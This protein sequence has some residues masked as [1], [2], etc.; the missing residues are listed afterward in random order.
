MFTTVS[1]SNDEAAQE[2]KATEL[3]KTEFS[4]KPD[5]AHPNPQFVAEMD[6]LIEDLNQDPEKIIPWQLMLCNRE[7]TTAAGTIGFEIGDIGGIRVIVTYSS[8]PGYPNN[9]SWSWSVCNSDCRC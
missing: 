6:A 8:Y 4:A 9:I 5:D 7:I 1:C 3:T 2:A